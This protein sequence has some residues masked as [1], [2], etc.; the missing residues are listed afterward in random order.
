[1]KEEGLENV[2]LASD[3]TKMQQEGDKKLRDMAKDFKVKGKK[4]VRITKGE[5]GALRWKMVE[6]GED[7]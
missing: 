6:D 2:H 3:L 1:M 7:Y 5:I 4:N